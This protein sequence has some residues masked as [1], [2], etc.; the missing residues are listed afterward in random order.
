MKKYLILLILSLSCFK[1]M[2]AAHTK[3]GWMYYQYL[4]PGLVDP[5]KNLYKVGLNLYMIC[6]PNS[7]Q[8]DN[9]INF[10]IFNGGTNAFI[11]DVSVSINTNVNTQNCTS[12][13]CH[14]CIDLVPSI[15]YKVINYETTV[16]LAPSPSGYIISKQR[17]CRIVGLAN[18]P[19]SNSVGATYT[20]KIPGSV[21]AVPN[22]DHN[23]SPQFIFNDTS[24]VCGNNLFSINFTATDPD[25][26]SLVYAFCDAYTGASP[27]APSP[28]TASPPP[29]SPVPYIAPFSG[30]T[31][32]GALATI[33]SNTGVISGTAPASGEYVLCVCV[34]EYRN[35]IF[36]AESRK[37]LHLVVGDCFPV[38]AT[39]N[40]DH[41]TCDGFTQTF[42]NLSD[43]P[44]IQNW[45]WNFGDPA[46]GP[47]DTSTLQ[48]PTHTFT[49]AGF[50]TIK[51]KVNIGLPCVDSTTETLGVFPGFFPGFTT[52][53]PAC[54]NTPVQ[55]TDT[56]RTN[57]G[58][59]DTWRWDFGD[60]LILSDTSHVRN[61]VYTYPNSGTYTVQF[62]VSNSKG[63]KDTLYKD[64]VINE[65]PVLT[66]FPHDTSYCGLDTLQLT[67]TGT[68]TFSWTPNTNII[69]AN[70]ATPLVYPAT[71]TRY[72][73][74][75]S[76]N[77][78][79]AKDSA[80]VTPK[81]DLTN[82]ITASTNIICEE[83]TL[84][85][86]GNSNYTNNVSWQW[87]PPATIENP[88]N[89]VTRAYPIVNTVYNL[90]TTWGLHCVANATI[91][92]TVKPLAIAEA[93]PDTA[94]CSGQ[95]SVQLNATGGNT[96][97]WTPVAG[98]SNPNIPNPIATPAVTTTYIVSV[99]VTGCTKTRSDS[100]VVSVRQA[101]A[102]SVLP[103]DTLICNIDT[104]QLNPVGTGAYTWS[105]NY[106]INDIHSP[107]PLVSPDVTTLYHA[108][109]TDA[110]GCYSDDS[111]LVRVKTVVTIDA[112]ND[113]S[114]CKTDGFF[115]NTTSDALHYIWTPNLY[116]NS[117]TAKRPFVT[118]QTS[119]MYHVIGNIGKCQNQDSVFIK[120]TPYPI[121]N[122]GP[123]TSVCPGF[124]VTLQ[125]SGGTSYFWSPANFL[126]NR[127]ISNPVVINPSASIRYIV[128]VT[129]TLGCPKPGRDT[130]FVKV[131]PKL[132]VD[133]GP[134][135]TS[136]V[137]G[138]PLLLTATGGGPGTTYLWSPG[139]WLSSINTATTIALP[140]A[141]IEYIVMGMS[142]AGCLGTD[143]I[144]VKLYKI[145]PDMY[146]PNSFTPNKDGLNDV[147]RPIMIGMKE[148][149]YFRVYNR[150]GQ[151]LFSTS[152]IGKGWD[153]TFG[154]RAQDPA[155]YV[156]M[157]EG[158]TYKGDV[159]FKKGY[160]I[161]I[162]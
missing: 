154:G 45:Y 68:G 83:D 69:G 160:A 94:I 89:K 129:D 53:Q 50:Y 64:V 118:P 26:D 74:T 58:I 66:L 141:D 108:R 44:A 41:T 142:P 32:L 109:L 110:F 59:V 119:Q 151:L 148:L 143:S 152:D 31:P 135:D 120:V 114:V 71:P 11:Q 157:A 117:D 65:P 60:P 104:L 86:T 42:S 105:P 47:N 97:Q 36:F 107:N 3:G 149:T 133:A 4:G 90:T 24:I 87:S 34:F 161:L 33:N 20:I 100:V 6:N 93:G 122:A 115:I 82:S 139:L 15:C 77:G 127:F 146:V 62:I 137:E 9:P 128:T 131:M 51:L 136:V 99:G 19:N 63:C 124:N 8:I 46:S 123:D 52:S 106:M 23:S 85:L 1:Q 153:G 95:G 132:I 61:P 92:I 10:S 150:F 98:L 155:T 27:G 56:T 12:S 88:T 81:N 57:Y 79:L 38:H 140:H 39:L 78:C 54:K 75:L 5:T 138:Q 125:A 126:S 112:G 37:E 147:L 7:G 80:L 22:A 102:L 70:T 55:F 76:N 134:R 145:D 35:G 21:A 14:P 156:W 67:A 43:N 144:R 159:R 40:P 72:V 113:T 116:L 25:G 158:V 17:C 29:Y 16:E 103:K 101:P 91:P 28:A 73:V 48:N 84:T 130:V 30:T 18:I 162:R 2:F 96:Y 49:V 13:S 111:I 121:A